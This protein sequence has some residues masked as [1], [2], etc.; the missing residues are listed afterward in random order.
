MPRGK[1]QRTGRRAF[2]CLPQNRTEL[3]R[4]DARD[5]RQ[6]ATDATSRIKRVASDSSEA[7]SGHAEKR[8]G[9]HAPA[10]GFPMKETPVAGGGFKRMAKRVPIIQYLAQTAFV[11]VLAHHVCFDANTARDNPGQSFG[12][13]AKQ[14][15]HA[16]FEEAKECRIG[17]DAI[18]DDFVK[19]G[20]KFAVRQA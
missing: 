2:S 11:L 17:D 19:T 14:S 8:G 12:I 5:G 15:G 9:D 6:R 4:A 18:F 10:D 13:A 20:A 7:I 1:T 3:R 16:L